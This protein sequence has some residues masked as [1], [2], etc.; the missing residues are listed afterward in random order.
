MTLDHIEHEILRTDFNE[1]RIHMALVC[2]SKGCT[3]LAGVP[4][5]GEALNEQL[6]YYTALFVNNPDKIRLDQEKNTVFLSKYFQ[7]FGEDFVPAYGT[8][9][10]FTSFN[11]IERAALNFISRYVSED[12]QQYLADDG[13]SIEYLG[14][15][16]SLNE[17]E[18]KE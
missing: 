9:K 14:Y 2:A 10:K 12:D 18:E 4:Y 8:D 15:D 6:N 13:Y 11:E 17:L 16:W 1:A 7:W 5:T 3:I